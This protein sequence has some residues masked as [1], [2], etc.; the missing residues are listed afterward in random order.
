MHKMLY[1]S[2]RAVDI[3]AALPG[4]D[5]DGSAQPVIPWGKETLTRCVR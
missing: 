2:Q 5:A 3:L 1:D 4:V